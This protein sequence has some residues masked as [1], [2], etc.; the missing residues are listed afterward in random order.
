MNKYDVIII[1]A[2]PAGLTAFNYLS[3]ANV[4]TLVIDGTI[5]GG[6]L[7]NLHE[8][9]NYPSEE[10]IDGPTLALKM[11]DHSKNLGLKVVKDS[12]IEIRS[13]EG[14]EVICSKEKYISKHVISATGTIDKKAGVPGEDKFFGRGVSYC[15]ICDGP[16][17]KGKDICV[18]G[19]YDHALEETLYLAGLAKKIYLVC[20][21]GQYT[22]R[23]IFAEIE[24]Q[25]N[26][27]VLFN[28]KVDSI[29][30]DK[31]VSSVNIGG[32]NIDV[33]YVFPLVGVSPST[34][35]ASR[36]DIVN[37]KVSRYENGKQQT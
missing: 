28:S 34:N 31:S 7:V 22:N 21:R 35:F 12:V 29:N 17:C 18:I 27:E 16:L 23:E 32:K 30:G 14:F 25:K 20:S 1:G 36:L 8:I 9:N 6:K 19:D 15:A 4:N 3:L 37:D 11:L 10:K 26:I 13:G 24:K 2:G 5:P 33:S